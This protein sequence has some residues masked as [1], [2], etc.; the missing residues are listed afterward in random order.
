MKHNQ[1][2]NAGAESSAGV[3]AQRTALAHL[4][5]QTTNKNFFAIQL[6][7]CPRITKKLLGP[8]RFAIVWER[9]LSLAL[10]LIHNKLNLTARK[11]L[12]LIGKLTAFSQLQ[13][14][15]QRHLPVEDSFTFAV[16]L[17]LLG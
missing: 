16:R 15:S 6:T 2:G 14:F 9:L 4:K 5:P 1:I 13:E 7:L 3:L 12:S 17:S 10:A 8:L 11:S